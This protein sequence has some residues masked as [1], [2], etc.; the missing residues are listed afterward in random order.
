MARISFQPSGRSVEVSAGTTLLDAVVAAGLPIARACG[1]DGLC[2]R[3]GVYVVAGAGAIG[4]ESEAEAAA[5]G[6]N[7]IDP[8]IRLACQARVLGDLQLTTS[9]W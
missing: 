4:P 7:R 1:R 6:R 2:G 8:A 9:Y 3:C 5:K